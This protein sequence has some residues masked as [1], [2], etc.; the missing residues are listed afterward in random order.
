MITSG[1]VLIGLLIFLAGFLWGIVVD[2]DPG[3]AMPVLLIW[4]FIAVFTFAWW[5]KS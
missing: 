2:D 4:M 5:L 3:K 1:L